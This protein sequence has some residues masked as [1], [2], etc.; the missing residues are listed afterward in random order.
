MSSSSI[1]T[2]SRTC[3]NASV[4]WI[5]PATRG[6]EHVPCNVLLNALLQSQRQVAMISEMI[7]SASLIH[8]D[9]ID[10]SD[11]RRGKPSVNVLWN[12]KKGCD[13]PAPRRNG[14]PRQPAQFSFVIERHVYLLM[15]VFGRRPRRRIW[16]KIN[17]IQRFGSLN[18]GSFVRRCRPPPEHLITFSLLRF[19]RDPVPCYIFFLD[20]FGHR[21]AC[22]K[23]PTAH[24]DWAGGPR[25]DGPLARTHRRRV[26][27]H[28]FTRIRSTLKSR[29]G[30]HGESAGAADERAGHLAFPI[31]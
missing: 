28:A 25:A 22:G 4:S 24:S 1:S 18:T 15:S 9:V 6:R 16:V 10:Q 26:R 2:L 17:A 12:H 20:P 19:Q 13:C 31:H 14:V 21:N 11:F 8:D 5:R 23:W 30:S 7:H 29:S 3:S 27:T